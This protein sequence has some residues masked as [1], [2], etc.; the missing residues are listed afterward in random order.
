MKKLLCLL[1]FLPTFSF[2]QNTNDANS[3]RGEQN[4]ELSFAEKKNVSYDAALTAGTTGVG[5][6]FGVRPISLLKIRAGFSYMPKIAYNSSY[7]MSSVSDQPQTEEQE[8]RI[9]KLCNLL[10][11][12]IN[13]DNID[14]FISMNHRLNFWNAKVLIDF[15]PFQKK[16][17]HFTVGAYVGP[18]KLGRA[19]NL[20]SE[21]ATMTAIKIYNIQYDKI[22]ADPYYFPTFSLTDDISFEMDPIAG[23]AA[24]ESFL[25]YGRVVVP[26]GVFN[27]DYSDP[28][29]A[30]KPHYLEPDEDG[31]MH[32]TIT[33]H[34]VKPYVGVGYDF[35]FG[36]QNR[37][38]FAVDAGALILGK[39]PHVRDNM[40]VCLT[41]DVHGIGGDVG[42]LVRLVK[43]FPVYPNLELRLSYTIH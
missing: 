7:S 41:H 37:W 30:G 38:N 28:A 5:F 17:W 11:N 35:N 29:L 10:G 15:Y 21:A 6:E 40:G 18:K 32:A 3:W 12:F 4:N 1:A 8:K 43:K 22:A 36:E 27:D 34:I 33:S 19:I 39:A 23:I 24:R 31:V 16:N 14:P 9:N 20:S 42:D 26:M 13:S 25:R 2:A